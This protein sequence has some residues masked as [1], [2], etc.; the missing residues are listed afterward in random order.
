MNLLSIFLIDLRVEIRCLS[1]L[2][3]LECPNT[4]NLKL[5][6]FYTTKKKNYGQRVSAWMLRRR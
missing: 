2:K 4:L 3:S 6:E 1:H 5:E